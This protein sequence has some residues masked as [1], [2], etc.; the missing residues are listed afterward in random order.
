MR[1]TSRE[2]EIYM[3]KSWDLNE[4]SMR[5]I[6]RDDKINTKIVRYLDDG[7]LDQNEESMRYT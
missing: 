1:S 2:L 5:S 6:W 4:G 7:T 3:N